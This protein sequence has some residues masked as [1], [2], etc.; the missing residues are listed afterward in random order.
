MVTLKD[1]LIKRT[2]WSPEMATVN[3]T[4]DS[5][6]PSGLQSW[7]HHLLV[8][9]LLSKSQVPHLKMEMIIVLASYG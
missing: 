3:M 8:A 2:L 1:Q 9:K 4:V 7:A 6:L 5:V